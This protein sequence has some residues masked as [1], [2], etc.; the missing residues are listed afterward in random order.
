MN[1]KGRTIFYGVAGA[2]LIY[3]AYDMFQTKAATQDIKLLI[4]SVVF[5]IAG[6]L[7]LL[8]AGKSYKSYMTEEMSDKPEEEEEK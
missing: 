7:L 5:G 8:M 6:V 2:Y 1:E 3:L 4:F